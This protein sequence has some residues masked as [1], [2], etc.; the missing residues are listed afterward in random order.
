V[1]LAAQSIAKL[2]F[3]KT[4]D[5]I[6]AI[7]NISSSISPEVALSFPQIIIAG[8]EYSGKSSVLER[9]TMLSFYPRYDICFRM[10]MQ[11]QFKHLSKE[12][13]K[14][15]CQTNKLVYTETSVSCIVFVSYQ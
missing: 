15:F 7:D 10:P 11:I 14:T 2:L 6:E 1:T 13:I 12:N 8:P 5:L 9:I 4:G 3:G